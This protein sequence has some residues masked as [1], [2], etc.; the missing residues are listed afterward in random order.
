MKAKNS[1]PTFKALWLAV[2][3]ASGL[4][5]QAATQTQTLNLQVGWNAVWLGVAP[6]N[7]NGSAQT[8]DQVFQ[9]SGFTID[10]VA[11]PVN[12]VGTAEFVS[13]PGVT[14]NQPGWLV[15]Y[16]DPVSG[17]N[18]IFPVPG[19]QAYLIHV[20]SGNGAANGTLAGSITISGEVKFFEP[21][22][23]VGAYNLIG[24]NVSGSVTFSDYLAALGDTDISA[25]GSIPVVQR[26]DSASGGWVGANG[27]E[28]IQAGEAYWVWAPTSLRDPHY[29]GPVAVDADGSGG[30]NFG[31]GPG[32]IEVPDPQGTAGDTLLLSKAELTFANLDATA[33][34][35]ITITKISPASDDLRL[36]ALEPQP[37]SLAWQIPSGSGVAPIS[38][39]NVLDLAAQTAKTVT[40]GA[41]RNWTS[42]LPTREN[43]YRIEVSLASGACYFW[44]PVKA[45][46]S[47][48][49][50][51]PAIGQADAAVYTGLWVGEVAL[52]NVTSLAESGAPL[53]PATSSLPIE[54]ILHSD[55]TNP[56]VLLS[57]VL[58]MKTKTSDEEIASEP[59]LVLDEAKIPYFEGIEERGGKL[60]GRRIESVAYDLPRKLDLVTQAALATAH[61]LGT[62]AA[63][64][65]YVNGQTARPP[66]LVEEYYSTWPLA[67]TLEPNGQVRTASTA[68]GD[69]TDSP[70]SLDPFHRSNPFRHAFHPSHGAGYAIERSFTIT[71]DETHEDG[72]LRGTYRESVT[73]LT[74]SA[75]PLQVQGSITLR[76]ITDIAELQ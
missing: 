9:G 31:N 51:V 33:A 23:K 7:T 10:V 32:T 5:L 66:E 12:P 57:H 74:A 28:S 38:T 69:A 61:G 55:G 15:W 13:D 71:F 34:H 47:D 29:A 2:L 18:D 59:V 64:T 58:L 49:S 1:Q 48:L 27:T 40:V 19:E 72:L 65:A 14:F 75:N 35:A 68:A 22:W 70:L 16:L 11:R 56:P 43:L 17:G 50:A 4:G 24:F 67:G 42:G 76:R 20:T 63:L 21:S 46:R 52:K 62:T 26:L 3:L 44:L 8:V 30:L 60:V 37:A 45:S 39:W 6:I 25:G 54:I 41:D 73:G 36:F 53:K